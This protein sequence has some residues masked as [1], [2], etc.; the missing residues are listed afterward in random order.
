NKTK[1]MSEP[2]SPEVKMEVTED[3]DD[4]AYGRSGLMSLPESIFSKTEEDR[5]AGQ[6]GRQRK[7]VMTGLSGS[8]FTTRGKLQLPVIN[9]NVFKN[10]EAGGQRYDQKSV[11][12]HVVP[13]FGQVGA[14]IIPSSA[15]LPNTA[16]SASTSLSKPVSNASSVISSS[17]SAASSL[18][19]LT[20]SNDT[21]TL[22]NMQAR[23][24]QMLLKKY[25]IDPSNE[26][27]TTSS[28]SPLHST[29]L[30]SAPL[31]RASPITSPLTT[32]RSVPSPFQTQGTLF[33]SQAGVQISEGSS[34]GNRGQAT[35]RN[36]SPNT[37]NQQIPLYQHQLVAVFGNNHRHLTQ[38]GAPLESDD[39]KALESPLNLSTSG[40]QDASDGRSA[41]SS[42]VQAE[43]S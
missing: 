29:T 41:I 32:S 10:S 20:S 15:S 5:R 6:C 42:Q 43:V 2:S 12:L 25:N 11:L 17:L 36:G 16:Q 7:V 35:E 4:E 28:I 33:Y 30:S 27:A 9:S 21:V 40:R 8:L 3:K 37:F 1:S 22:T 34:A 38:N 18:S 26:V 39:S 19:H 13:S 14:S 31:K 24:F 23:L